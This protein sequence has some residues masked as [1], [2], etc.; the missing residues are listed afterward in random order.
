MLSIFLTSLLNWGPLI[1]AQREQHHMS[2]P[3]K[4]LYVFFD[5]QP[6]DIFAFML[7]LPELHV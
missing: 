4:M 5:G 1:G 3:I 6:V 7:V 2:Y